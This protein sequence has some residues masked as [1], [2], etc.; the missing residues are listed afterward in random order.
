MVVHGDIEAVSI[1]VWECRSTYGPT[2]AQQASRRIRI[3]F[4]KEEVEDDKDA[5]EWER[6]A[7]H[8]PTEKVGEK[9]E[10]DK[11]SWLR[12]KSRFCDRLLT[13]DSFFLLWS[14]G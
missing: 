13:F 1:E 11:H 9:K 10:T 6:L 2:N 12:N 7:G 5:V 4:L 14:A 8:C 3:V